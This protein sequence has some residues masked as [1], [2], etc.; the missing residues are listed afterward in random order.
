MLGIYAFIYRPAILRSADKFSRPSLAFVECL[1]VTNVKIFRIFLSLPFQ[2]LLLLY[3]V[4]LFQVAD[5]VFLSK[6]CIFLSLVLS[7]SCVL[8]YVLA[9][10]VN[11]SF[12]N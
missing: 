5:H 8:V 4:S 11:L 7:F 12:R 3:L 9:V 10:I 6:V 2:I 1:R